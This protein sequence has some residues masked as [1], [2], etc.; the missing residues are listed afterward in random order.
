[1]SLACYKATRQKATRSAFT[2]VE[3]LVVITIIGLLAGLLTVGLYAAFGRGKDFVITNEISQV[4][5]SLE[6]YKAKYG[7]YPPDMSDFSNASLTNGQLT[8]FNA[9]INK[10]YPRANRQAIADF[11]AWVLTV[12]NCQIDQAEALVLFLSLTS[13]DP[14]YPFGRANTPG[15]PSTFVIPAANTLQV[16]H[17]F[18]PATLLDGD[19]DGFPEFIQRSTKTVSHWSTSTPAPI[20]P[21]PSQLAHCKSASTT[22]A[23]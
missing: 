13:S 4:G 10:A 11:R 9:F 22:R 12:R 2:L 15:D 18:P 5:M 16:L 19:N 6:S 21:C 3:L 8:F 1:M 14:I 20:P 17:E 7:C 23:M